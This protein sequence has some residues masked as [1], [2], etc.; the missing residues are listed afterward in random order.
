MA[1]WVR[2]GSRIAF[3][4]GLGIAQ[5]VA[6]SS[7]SGNGVMEVQ[8]TGTLGLALQ[9]MGPS[10]N[11][12]RLRDAVFQITERRTGDVVD[13][14]FSEDMPPSAPELRKVLLTGN[15]DV[16][17]LDGW[18]IERIRGGSVGS[19]GSAGTG[20][21]G[22]GGSA[23]KIGAGG[24]FAG[25]GGSTGKG[26]KGGGIGKGGSTS[27]GG[28][29]GNAGEFE[30]EFGG[31]FGSAGD[32]G[33]GGTGA[34]GGTGGSFGEA[35]GFGEGGSFAVGGGPGSGAT[36]GTFPDGG[37]GGTDVPGFPEVV[38]AQL[39]SDAI[40]SFFLFGFDEAF[41]RYTFH[42]GAE[43]LDFEHGRLHIGID[44]IENPEECET[45]EGVIDPARVLLETNLEA[46]G[47][48]SLRDVFDALAS[49][50]EMSGDG[51]RL[52]Q[53]VID[54]YASA[55]QGVL[56]D[57]VHCGDETT[58]GVPTL[59]G[60]PI[61]CNRFEHNHID[62]P[63]GFFATAFVNRMDLAPQN[64]AHCGQQRVI[65]SSNTFS[66][67]FMILE[68][69]IPNPAPE[70]GIQGCAP[71]AQFWLDQ[72]S[73]DDAFVRGER[74]REAFLT[75][76]P[77][78]E[79][80]GFGPFMTATN[81]TIGSG[82]IRTNQFDSF[83]WTLREFKLALDGASVTA[84]PF[85]VAESPPGLLWNENIDS[86]QGEACRESF[87]N[88]VGGLLTNDLNQMSFIVDDIC[89]DSES[90]NDF[91]ENYVSQLS[92]GF[93]G[94][95]EERLLGTNLTPE[96][97]AN[98][99]QFAGSCIGCHVE[100]NGAFL[101]DGVTAPFS[102]DFVHVFEFPSR[103]ESEQGECFTPSPALRQAFLPSRM[104]VLGQVLDIPIVEDPC[105]G[106]SGGIGGTGGTSVGGAFSTGGFP[107]TGG[108]GSG[109]SPGA[110]GFGTG[111]FFDEGSVPAPE[112]DIELPSVEESIV[113]LQAEE[114]AIRDLYGEFTLSGKSAK[115]TH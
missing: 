96:D 27:K 107:G 34:V 17:L 65:F 19:G 69:Q 68:A 88:A 54:S 57:A 76:A 110:G 61:T 35:G 26:G 79:A 24:T 44:I 105:N 86:P 82:Q 16:Q 14:L 3:V 8:R 36:G 21:V 47:S 94:Q 2:S 28:G 72:D 11:V 33:V 20:A 102:N 50:A 12:Y 95:L 32:F 89:K 22:S 103:C 55:D 97:A 5:L 7:D 49:N 77:D 15:Y 67:M 108:F 98:R 51:F 75:G 91:S 85:P 58:D 37:V 113:E 18:F 6:C 81:L 13:F 1:R 45:P 114:E 74:L 80:F 25:K 52:Y 92:E 42:V 78:L 71:L 64:G 38:E 100:A 53:E 83:P 106:G 10:G 62:D 87:L 56:A 30:E 112:V 104:R 109:A 23:G 73:I 41:V 66:R 43:E 46:L 59:N 70:L 39:V 48:T 31:A 101:G 111:G 99:A 60:Y 63:E 40:Q 84:I 29:G 9:T 90:R 4:V 115:S 93:R